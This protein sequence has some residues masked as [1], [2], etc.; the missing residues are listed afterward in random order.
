M[1]PTI[2]TAAAE[3]RIK[4]LAKH[5]ASS[6]FAQTCSTPVQMSVRSYG[7][8]IAGDIQTISY[9]VIA[10]VQECAGP[11][12]ARPVAVTQFAR[13]VGQVS[14]EMIPVRVELILFTSIIE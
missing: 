13:P 6:E 9:K 8:D 4:I 14:E 5:L 2:E 12:F 10:G 7:G 1:S 3:A 11:A